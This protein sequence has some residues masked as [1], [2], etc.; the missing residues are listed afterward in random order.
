LLDLTEPHRREK[1]AFEL[2]QF[3][4]SL[5]PCFL[6]WTLFLVELFGFLYCRLFVVEVVE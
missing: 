3:Y 4:L 6:S 5:V 1:K 2:T